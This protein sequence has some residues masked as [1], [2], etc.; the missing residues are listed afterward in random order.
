MALQAPVKSSLVAVGGTSD[1]IAL[2]NYFNFSLTGTWVGTV[3]LERSFDNGL[4]WNTVDSFTSNIESVGQDPE[5]A[6]YRARCSAY[7]SGSANVRLGQ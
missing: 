6:L 7:T 1:T 5:G 2:S 3:V 4:T